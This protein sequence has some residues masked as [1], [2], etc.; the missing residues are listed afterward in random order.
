M[1]SP[2]NVFVPIKPPQSNVATNILSHLILPGAGSVSITAAFVRDC[3]PGH[4]YIEATSPEVVRRSLVGMSAFVRWREGILLVPIPERIQLL[5][6]SEFD[7]FA[8]DWVRVKRGLYRHD[9]GFVLGHENFSSSVTFAVVPR[10]SYNP[11]STHAKTGT[12]RQASPTRPSQALLDVD[13][14]RRLGKVQGSRSR[15]G[16]LKFQGM[17][18]HGGL[19]IRQHS[20]HDLIAKG[21]TPRYHEIQLFRAS[22]CI[23]LSIIRNWQIADSLANLQAGNRVEILTGELKGSLA[24]VNDIQ[25]RIL[26]VELLDV[27]ENTGI[28]Q[29]I[30]QLPKE[31]V[32][33]AFLPGDFVQ[34][35]HGRDAGNRGYVVTTSELAGQSMV[36]FYRHDSLIENI[37]PVS[38]FQ[39]VHLLR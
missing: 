28:C 30:L 11:D 4:I 21:V 13:R 22:P 16:Y 7:A 20:V 5:R 26:K 14:A 17:Y 8:S 15:K 29:D 1:F 10:L 2:E 3:L 18:F 6:M 27:S 39:S 19:L 25:D 35:R 38:L 37:P 32:R 24:L 33:K 34:V 12:K 23:D 9:L 31:H 36:A